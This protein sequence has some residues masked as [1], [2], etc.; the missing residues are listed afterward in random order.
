M[1]SFRAC[2]LYHLSDQLSEV[3]WRSWLLVIADCFELSCGLF[4]W[5]SAHSICVDWSR[6][7]SLTGRPIVMTGRCFAISAEITKMCFRSSICEAKR[8]SGGV[9]VR[10]FSASA[11]GGARPRRPDDAFAQIFIVGE[12]RSITNIAF[13]D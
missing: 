6:S 2:H 1:S 10:A 8:W 4:S 5:G 9:L 12:S 11:E 3:S 7:H 13:L